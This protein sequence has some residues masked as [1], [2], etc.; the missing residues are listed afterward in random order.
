MDGITRGS[1]EW[2]FIN[3]TRWLSASCEAVEGEPHRVMLHAELGLVFDSHG[4]S[5]APSVGLEARL[6]TGKNFCACHLLALWWEMKLDMSRIRI[7]RDVENHEMPVAEIA[8]GSTQDSV[9][10][11][12]RGRPIDMAF[13]KHL[14][15]TAFPSVYI[16]G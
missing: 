4:Q 16:I 15:K 9:L 14:V 7:H 13:F 2:P 1:L 5:L 3:E 8:T 10:C 6:I 11:H 12:L